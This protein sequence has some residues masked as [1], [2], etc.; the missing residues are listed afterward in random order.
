[1]SQNSELKQLLESIIEVIQLNH[2]TH[3]EM[4]ATCGG[5]A[6]SDLCELN[7]TAIHELQKLITMVD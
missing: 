5:Y 7:V 6:T 1:M 2:D 3:E 4:D